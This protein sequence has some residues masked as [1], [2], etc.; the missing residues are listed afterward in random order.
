MK[1]GTSRT[2][3]ANSRSVERQWLLLNADNQVLGRIASRAA[4]L[5]MGK[6]KPVFT[7]HVDCGD[8]VIIIN[9]EKVRLTGRK[10]QQK[11]MVTFSGYP[12][13]LKK[14]T[15]AKVLAKKPEYLL[16]EAIRGMLPKTRLGAAMYR[17]LHVFRG[18]EHPF[19]AQKPVLIK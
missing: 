19:A 14:T 7:P 11:E 12:G 5:L 4:R 2:Q 1:T 6:H 9:A 17:K 16:E 10:M 18:Q 3:H 13:G 15:P 8:H